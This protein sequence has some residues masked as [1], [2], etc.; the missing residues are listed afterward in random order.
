M[1]QRYLHI[2]GQ[3]SNQIPDFKFELSD[4]AATHNNRVFARLHYNLAT[5]LGAQHSTM[6]RP[7]FNFKAT[8][9]LEP[10]CCHLPL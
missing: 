10:L 1:Q 2:D 8:E 7:G 6:L 9:N 5:K 3:D 4:S